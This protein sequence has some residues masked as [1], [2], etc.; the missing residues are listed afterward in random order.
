MGKNNNKQQKMAASSAVFRS[1]K[2]LLNLRAISKSLRCNI[3]CTQRLSDK[4]THTGQKFDNEDWKKM[5]FTAPGKDK[6]VNTNI[7]FDMVAEEPPVEVN[8][9]IVSCDGGGGA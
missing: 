7:A 1:T 6:L 2:Q 8:A 3:A 5:R 9:R 4:V